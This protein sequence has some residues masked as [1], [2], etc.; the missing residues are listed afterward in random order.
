MTFRSQINAVVKIAKREI[1]DIRHDSDIFMIILVAPLF[2]AFFYGGVYVN[3]GEH[4]VPVAVVDCDHSSL[5]REL[6]RRIDATQLVKVVEE[7]GDPGIGERLLEDGKVEG[8][9]VIPEG[10]E[11]DVLRGQGSDVMLELNTARFLVSND[12]N[13]GITEAAMSLGNTPR[14]GQAG[15]NRGLRVDVHPMFN[16]TE[17]YGDFLIPAILIV[18]LQQTFWIGLS[19]SVAKERSS[20]SLGGLVENMA[21][22]RI[23]PALAGKLVFYLIVFSAYAFFLYTVHLSVFSIPFRG[24]PTL[25]AALLLLFLLAVG[26]VGFFIAS[27]FPRKLLALQVLGFTS[28]PIFLMS[29]YSWPAIA[30][31]GLLRG[32][33]QLFPMTPFLAASTRILQMNAGVTDVLPETIHLIMLL[34]LGWGLSAWR[35]RTLVAQEH[36]SA[37]AEGAA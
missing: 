1:E 22:G 29:G 25:L 36:S 28:Y 26:G 13:K 34:I 7:T 11:K 31:P 12:M 20:G 30:V 14:G 8:A 23:L 27:F 33:S 16:T 18:I 32:L 9:V 15:S 6:S 21:G 4:D 24:S 19:E 2:Y 3:K 5:S 10:F 37:R 17:T 35:L